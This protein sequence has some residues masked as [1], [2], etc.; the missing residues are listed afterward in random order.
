[1]IGFTATETEE[2]FG[3]LSILN[4]GRGDVEVKFSKKDQ[5]DIARAKLMIEDMMK[6]GY[7]LLVKQGDKYSTV[8][9]FDPK[10][11]VYIVVNVATE[12]QGEDLPIK[13]KGKKGRLK[14]EEIPMAKAK[15]VGIGRTAGG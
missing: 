5:G 6:R 12:S 7:A 11:E 4:V 8:Q 3:E 14:T 13:G 1:M 2:E 9:K 10:K 15:A